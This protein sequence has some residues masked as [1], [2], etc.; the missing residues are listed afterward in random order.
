MRGQNLFL[1]DYEIRI[2]PKK[3][4]FLT[5]YNCLKCVTL[6]LNIYCDN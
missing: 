6:N 4:V 3:D 5:L 2:L 1:T